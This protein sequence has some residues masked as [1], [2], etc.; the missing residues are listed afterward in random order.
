[1]IFFMRGFQIA[2]QVVLENRLS[3]KRNIV[4]VLY[5]IVVLYSVEGVWSNIESGLI[6]KV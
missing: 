6:V 3:V 5:C 1:M 2:F 4:D